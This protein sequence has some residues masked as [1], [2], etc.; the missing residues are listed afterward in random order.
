MEIARVSALIAGSLLAVVAVPFLIVLLIAGL[1]EG[2]AHMRFTAGFLALTIYVLATAGLSF[3]YAVR[4]PNGLGWVLSFLYVPA[5]IALVWMLR[6]QAQA[7]R[8]RAVVE[9][10]ITGEAADMV[11]V[12]EP[13]ARLVETEDDFQAINRLIQTL[14]TSA[15]LRLRLRIVALFAESSPPNGHAHMALRNLY[16][17]TTEKGGP[18]ELRV[19]VRDAILAISPD[20][21]ALVDALDRARDERSR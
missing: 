11:S 15:D 17:K 14:E 4:K 7:K 8:D 1:W 9:T 21:R 19:A 10:V 18:E 13:L 12:A 20:D 5:V 3:F 6:P 2:F 16:A